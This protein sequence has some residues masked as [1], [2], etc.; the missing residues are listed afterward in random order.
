[1]IAKKKKKIVKNRKTETRWLGLLSRNQGTKNLGM[2]GKGERD[3]CK[4]SFCRPLPQLWV[5]GAGCRKGADL[6]NQRKWR[7][8]AR[9]YEGKAGEMVRACNTS[10]E[11]QVLSLGWSGNS[12]G[13]MGRPY[14]PNKSFKVHPVCPTPHCSAGYWRP[15]ASQS[16]GPGSGKPV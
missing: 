4:S 6:R 12:S 1:M 14:P 15:A 9:G 16:H 3:I 10:L 11:A 13:K 2:V 8:G 7:R 5:W